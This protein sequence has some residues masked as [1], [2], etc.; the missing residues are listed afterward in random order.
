MLGAHRTGAIGYGAVTR[1]RQEAELRLRQ[2]DLS[3]HVAGDEL[4]VL[5][6]DG[7]TYLKLNG[8]GRVLWE[9]LADGSTRDDLVTVLVD[10]FEI[11]QNRAATDVETFVAE[12]QRRG[13][14]D[15]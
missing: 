5:D 9:Q 2:E 8:S 4:V 13:L 3:W 10:R 7:S 6:L 15:G 14:L 1:S 11:S 12:L